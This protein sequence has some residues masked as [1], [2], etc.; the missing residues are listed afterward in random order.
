MGKKKRK[1][2]FAGIVA[3]LLCMIFVMGTTVSAADTGSKMV[4]K[5]AESAS[6]EEGSGIDIVT[7]AAVAVVA[8]SVIV[9][10]IALIVGKKKKSA[11][12]DFGGLPPA[13][14]RKAGKAGKAGKAA[15]P[16][17]P[18]T[19]ISVSPPDETEDNKTVMLN[20]MKYMLVLKDR[21]DPSKVFKYPIMKEVVIGRSAGKGAQIVINYDPS[22]SSTHCLI[23]EVA[24]RFYVKDLNSVNGTLLNGVKVTSPKEFASRS[25]I[26]LGRLEMIVE[27]FEC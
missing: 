26:T 16:P 17:P 12:A 13:P 1:W 9:L 25:V 27:I 10:L 18:V 24:G 7:I 21:N 15:P 2:H 19:N 20:H 3:A 5:G 8:V 4:T 22:V 23:S 6:A 14:R 11:S